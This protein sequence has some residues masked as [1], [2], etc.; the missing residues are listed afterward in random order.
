ME[1]M[2]KV[3]EIEGDFAHYLQSEKKIL[4]EVDD[5]DL[6]LTTL[7]YYDYLSTNEL[8]DRARAMVEEE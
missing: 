3:G 8:I 7:K 6:E 1:S 5:Y 2:K 4:I